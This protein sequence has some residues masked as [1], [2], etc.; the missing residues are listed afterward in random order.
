MAAIHV[1]R[2]DYLTHPECQMSPL[3]DPELGLTLPSAYYTKALSSLPSGLKFAIF[4]D[5]PGFASE[6]FAHL[7]P[8]V[9]PGDSPARDMLLMSSCRFQVIANSSF[10]W[11]AAWLN[12]AQNKV[13]IAPR[14]HMGWR[15]RTWYPGDTEVDG[16]QYVDV[17]QRI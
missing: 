16:W 8:W 10:S 3:G 11:W 12:R 5:D 1:R 17:D 6:L 15:I 7:D 9:S 13:I 2:T 4:S 14:F